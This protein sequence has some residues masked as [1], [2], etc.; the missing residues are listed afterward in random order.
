MNKT[1]F[2]E[3]ADLTERLRLLNQNC[4]SKETTPYIRNLTQE[5][6]D[7]KRE[8]HVDNCIELDRLND[9][10]KIVK[11]EYKVKMEPVSEENKKL[12]RQI[13]TRQEELTGTI[14]NFSDFEEGMVNTYDEN[15]EFV[16]SRR[17]KPEERQLK[18]KLF[19]PS[20]VN[21]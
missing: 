17:M 19:I 1:M 6:L 5:E 16:G 20:A 9:E 10:L 8:T 14:F 3:E 7:F 11:A 15:G 21:Q 13:K 2:A 4:D 12:L 18:A